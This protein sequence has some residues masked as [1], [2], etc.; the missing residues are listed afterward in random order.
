MGRSQTFF[1]VAAST[2]EKWPGLLRHLTAHHGMAFG[3]NARVV[4]GGRM[5]IGEDVELRPATASDGSGR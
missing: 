1:P 2:Q 4:A 5:E 3:I